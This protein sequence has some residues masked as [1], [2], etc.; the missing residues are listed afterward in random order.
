MSVKFCLPRRTAPTVAKNKEPQYTTHM[1]PTVIILT[2]PPGAGKTTH[3]HTHHPHLPLLDMDDIHATTLKEK[4]KKF[5]QRKLQLQ[6]QRED[7]VLTTAAPSNDH[8][9]WWLKQFPGFNIILFAFVPP[10]MV[11]YQR[12]Q[13]RGHHDKLERG[14]QQWYKRYSP[15]RRELR[16]EGYGGPTGA[17]GGSYRSLVARHGAAHCLIEQQDDTG[18]TEPPLYKEGRSAVLPECL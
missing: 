4:K 7:F 12:M 5:K 1:K 16:A 6:S 10:R 8:K 13:Q 18:T 14:I 3:Y 11:A 17:R 15:H 2:G 9:E